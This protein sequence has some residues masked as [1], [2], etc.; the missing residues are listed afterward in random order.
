[1]I[2]SAKIFRPDYSFWSKNP[3]KMDVKITRMLASERSGTQI[4]LKCLKSLGV[5]AFLPPP[6]GAQATTNLVSFTC[7]KMSFLVS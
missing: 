7:L 6:G 4:M 1:M 3:F 2:G 5:T